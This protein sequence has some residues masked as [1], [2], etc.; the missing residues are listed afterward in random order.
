MK[1]KIWESDDYF[2]PIGLER[3]DMDPAVVRILDDVIPLS[4]GFYDNGILFGTVSDIRLE[5]GELV[6]EATFTNQD[7]KADI[8]R[9]LEEG[10][11]RFGGYYGSIERTQE[12]DGSGSR[13]VSCDLRSVGIVKIQNMPGFPKE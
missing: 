2:L 9:L 7:K 12:L 1:I 6:G 8:V 3:I 5:D 11:I 13:I 10:L 4:W